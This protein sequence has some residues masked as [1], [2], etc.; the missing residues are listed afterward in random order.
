LYGR[1]RAGRAGRL[2][3]AAQ[4]ALKALGRQALHAKTLGFLHP[5]TGERLRFDTDLPQ[6]LNALITSL[7]R[8]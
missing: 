3:A 5:A 8:L 2:P 1:S 6:D 4:A 7:E